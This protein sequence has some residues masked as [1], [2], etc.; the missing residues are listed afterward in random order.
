MP[1]DYDRF[2]VLL[3]VTDDVHEMQHRFL[4]EFKAVRLV[5]SIANPY[6][7]ENGS[8]IILMK[9][10]SEAMRKAFREKIERDRLKTTAQGTAQTLKPDPFGEGGAMH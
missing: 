5:D 8:L 6:A 10:P 9:G 2:D 4:K 7:R 3:L 1:A